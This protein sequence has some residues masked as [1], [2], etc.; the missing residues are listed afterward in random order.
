LSFFMSMSILSIWLYIYL[1]KKKYL[2]YYEIWIIQYLAS[3][4][5]VDKRECPPD[6]SFKLCPLVG[7]FLKFD[8]RIPTH[9]PL[10]EKHLPKQ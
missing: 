5:L 10:V 1:D 3:L 4:N 9:L 2:L 6:F 7:V 8:F